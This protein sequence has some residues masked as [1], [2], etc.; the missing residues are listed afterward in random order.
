MAPTSATNRTT[1]SNS[2][3]AP[4]PPAAVTAAPLA[5]PSEV[6][7]AGYPGK[8]GDKTKVP[9]GLHFKN[10][11]GN[12][13]SMSPVKMLHAK[14]LMIV[15]SGLH[16]VQGEIQGEARGRAGCDFD[17]HVQLLRPPRCF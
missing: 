3:S 17:P 4:D 9:K 16:C 1:R 15:D 8:A 11:T 10:G 5:T 14:H 7:S 12:T 13:Y 6:A 2:K